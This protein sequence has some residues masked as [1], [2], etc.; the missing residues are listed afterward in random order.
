MNAWS[1]QESVPT[2][3]SAEDRSPWLVHRSF[4]SPAW[5]L[6]AAV[7]AG[8]LILPAYWHRSAVPDPPPIPE[9]IPNS[10]VALMEAVAA[11]LSRPLPTPMERV[12]LLLPNDDALDA[13]NI[14][15]REE[16]R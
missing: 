11:H 8:L 7:V 15:Q 14:D 6:G 5:A 16:I 3:Q 2:L 13:L 10:D 4:V 12:L 1:E 9:T